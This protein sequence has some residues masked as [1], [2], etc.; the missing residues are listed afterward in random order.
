MFASGGYFTGG[1]AFAGGGVGF[2]VSS[3]V[4]VSGSLS[5]AWSNTMVNGVVPTRTDLSGGASLALTSH[6]SIFGSVSH[7]L[8]TSDANSA[9]TT[10]VAGVSIVASPWGSRP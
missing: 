8:A 6:F 1:I 4:G 3:R 2:N 10:V 7:T 9:G 5:H